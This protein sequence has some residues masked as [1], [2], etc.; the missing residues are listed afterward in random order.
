MGLL[1][2][3]VAIVTGSAGAGV[4]QATVRLFLAEGAD[5]VVTDVNPARTERTAGMISEEIGR[6]VMWQPAD[7]TDK[8]S[9]EALVQATVER[10]GR[11]DILVNNA[12]RDIECRV[13]ELTDEIWHAVVDVCLLGT[14]YCTRAVLPTMMQQRSGS[15]VNIASVSSYTVKAAARRAHYSAAKAGIQGFTRGLAADMGEY[16]IRANVVMPASVPNDWMRRT[17]GEEFYQNSGK[18]HPLQ[19]GA[20]P[21]EI[22]KAI[23]FFA[24]D[25]SSYLTGEVLGAGAMKA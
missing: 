20:Q 17:F 8:A 24:S 7:V 23:L 1:D 13:D 6:E 16:G 5:V 10:Y 19:R 9:V 18:D 25:Q 2:G 11:I 12:Y 21:E 22:A 14:F 15:I 4:G 3:R